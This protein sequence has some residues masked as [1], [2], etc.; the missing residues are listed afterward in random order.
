[1]SEIETA[2]AEA[3]QRLPVSAKGVVLRNGSVA[4]LKNERNEWELPGGKIEPPEA[5][6][7]CVVREIREELGLEVE[8]IAEL[9]TWIY[10]IGPGATVRILTFG[11]AE[12]SPR[13]AVVS[14]EHS[15]MRWFPLADVPG[16]VMPEGYK[17]SIAAWAKMNES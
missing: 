7:A 17:Q 11:C 9:D 1:M 5:P 16:L 3:A 15:E 14:H 6:E 8:A 2:K 4:L 10:E 13:N 12:K